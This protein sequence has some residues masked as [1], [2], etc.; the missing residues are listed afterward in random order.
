MK[1]ILNF[2]YYVFVSFVLGIALLLLST[3]LPI[4]GN[5]KVK[6]VQSGSM[7]PTIKT[8]GVIIIHPRETYGVGDIV[9]FGLDTKTQIP[10]THRIIEVKG[11]GPLR[12]FT[13]QGDANDG[14]DPAVIRLSDI[15]GKVIFDLPYLGYLLDFAKKPTGFM[16]L[17][18]VPAFLIIFDEIGKIIK[19]IRRIRRKG[20]INVTEK[21]A[22]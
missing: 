6:V 16:L 3:I 14:P 8:G 11:D 15:H 13:T 21:N 9:T 17:V 20:Q 2:F 7:E 12:T 19:E 18:G 5:F 10:T 22:E 4:T 1:F